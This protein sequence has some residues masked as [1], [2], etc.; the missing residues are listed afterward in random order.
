VRRAAFV[1]AVLT[2]ATGALA[3]AGPGNPHTLPSPL[4]VHFRPHH[5]PWLGIE[6][7]PPSG[8]TVV[9][10]HVVRGSPADKAGI[11]DGDTVVSVDGTPVSSPGEVSRTVAGR[12]AGDSVDVVLRR[13]GRS[14]TV[15]VTLAPRPS[16]D[17]ILRM[18]YVGTFAPQLTG[19]TAAA[20]HVPA[21]VTALRGRVAVIEF[22]ATW[23][24]PCR[25]TMPVLDGWQSRYGAQGLSVLGITTEPATSAAA[26]ALQEGLHYA[27]AS[28]PTN[29]TSLAYGVRNIPTLFVVDKRGVVREVSIGYDAGTNARLEQLVQR[30][31]AEPSPR[32]HAP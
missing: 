5:L 27:V 9:V 17:D 10:Q 15:S 13:G 7:A 26:V 2:A 6:M 29:K 16:T 19:L 1:L 25:A 20:G 23:C 8:A 22:W 12:S 32:S 18:E 28:D 11:H 24:G 30:L 21:S 14:R 31:L 3:G 4:Q